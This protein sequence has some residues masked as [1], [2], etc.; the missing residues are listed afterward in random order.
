MRRPGDVI[1]QRDWREVPQEN[2][3]GVL[4]LAEHSVRVSGRNVKMLGS[5]QVRQFGRLF[6]ILREDQRSVI[7]QA[8]PREVTSRQLLKLLGQRFLNG[9][10]QRLVPRDE[11]SRSRTVFRL[12][13]Q[14][15]RH[16]I[17]SRGFIGE[18]DDLAGAGNAVDV[19][20]A[21]HV[22]LR[23]RD[24]QISRSDDLVDSPDPLD[25]VRQRGDRLS[26]AHAVNLGD[27]KLVA[28]G[29]KV[30]VVPAEIGR[31]HDNDDLFDAGHLSWHGRHQQR[32]R[33]RSGPTGNADAD[34]FQRQVTL[35]KSDS[36][37]A[38][39]VDQLNRLAEDRSLKSLDV[40]SNSA[41]RFQVL[42]ARQLV[43][44]REFAG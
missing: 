22:F 37:V 15:A 3:T 24:E 25:S 12:R 14:I 16:E 33:V 30:R 29:Q 11:D 41:H 1:A 44:G 20:L 31:R 10:D 19:D 4:N 34:P 13:N 27:P 36:V 32:R 35:S 28:G 39:A 21:E 18:D 42:R 9:C 23:E 2:R 43:R 5:H 40:R 7:E 38:L 6:R 17:G 8:L 26:S